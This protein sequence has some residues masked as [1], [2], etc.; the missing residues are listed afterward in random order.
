MNDYTA[1][2][3]VY[4]KQFEA[5][6]PARSAIAVAALPVNARIEIEMIARR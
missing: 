2:N 6:F 1:V 4:A 3:E 5:P